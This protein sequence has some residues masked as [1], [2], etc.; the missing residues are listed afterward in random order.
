MLKDNRQKLPNA[1]EK[2]KASE[3]IRNALDQRNLLRRKIKALQ[4]HYNT[5]N[6]RDLDDRIKSLDRRR[7]NAQNI[8]NGFRK[9]ICVI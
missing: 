2:K 5:P 6:T 7:I 1:L 9:P 3:F 4:R 8:K